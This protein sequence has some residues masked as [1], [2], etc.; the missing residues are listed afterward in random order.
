M[1]KVNILIWFLI[2]M[3]HSLF[4]MY[5]Y[6]NSKVKIIPKQSVHQGKEI[7]CFFSMPSVLLIKH[8][9]HLNIYRYRSN[10]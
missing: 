2:F 6:L 4:I 5:L 10:N 3:Y 1:L 7:G 8:P 9:P